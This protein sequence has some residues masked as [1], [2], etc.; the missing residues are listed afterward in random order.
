[1]KSQNLLFLVICL[2]VTPVNAQLIKSLDE[3]DRESFHAG[4]A[5]FD[6]GCISVN[7]RE[8]LIKHANAPKDIILDGV[9]QL[10]EGGDENERLSSLWSDTISAFVPGS[11]HGSLWEAGII[12]DP[13]FGRNDSIAEKYSYKT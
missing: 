13:Y 2:S 10:V 9:W 4:A 8:K 11:I 12:P 3:I 6:K 1:M 7:I 5:P